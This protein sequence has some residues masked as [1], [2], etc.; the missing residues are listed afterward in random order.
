MGEG[1]K[2][3]RK[4]GRG[5]EEKERGNGGRQAVRFLKIFFFGMHDTV[6]CLPN[7]HF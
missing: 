7:Q 1:K 6:C 4:S 5:E 3:G 2:E